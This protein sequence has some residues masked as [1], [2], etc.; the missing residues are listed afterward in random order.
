MDD[1]SPGLV[2]PAPPPENPDYSFWVCGLPGRLLKK[3][4]RAFE[5][6]GCTVEDVEGD[7]R[8]TSSTSRE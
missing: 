4:V 1:D 6:Q 3:I 7:L 8:I 5:S 2:A